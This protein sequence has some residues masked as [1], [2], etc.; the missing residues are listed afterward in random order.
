MAE[1]EK[2]ENSLAAFLKAATKQKSGVWLIT[3]AGVVFGEPATYEEYLAAAENR[4]PDPN[5]PRHVYL[6][7]QEIWLI[8]ATLHSGS[9]TFTLGPA[10]I[11]ADHVSGWGLFSRLTQ[12]P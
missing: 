5:S 12:T 2:E 1:S 9:K 6:T 4:N 7:G 11:L 3:P 8:R 10:V